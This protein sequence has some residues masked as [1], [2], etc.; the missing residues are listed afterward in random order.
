MIQAFGYVPMFLSK[1]PLVT[2][3]I[4]CFN[5]Y[6]D[7]KIYYMEKNNEKYPLREL[8]GNFECYNSKILN[9]LEK[10]KKLNLDYIYLNSF[11]IDEDNFIKVLSNLKNNKFNEI[12][13]LYKEELGFLEQKTVYRVKDL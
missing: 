2:N 12:F 3:Y 4:N 8:D 10:I 11:L 7:S 5:L 1:R 9:S 13:K 6:D